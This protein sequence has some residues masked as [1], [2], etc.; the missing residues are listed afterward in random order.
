[1]K[2]FILITAL[3]LCSLS[4]I[5]VSG[6]E[7]QTVEVQPGEDVTL[8]CSNFTGTVA[9]TFWYRLTD[10]SNISCISS[11]T[12]ADSNAFFYDGFRNGKFNMTSNITTLF[13]TIQQVDLSDSGLY[14][15]GLYIDR[16]PVIDSATYL[17]VQENPHGNTS[18]SVILG[19]VTVFL[20]I[21]VSAVAVKISKCQTADNEQNPQQSENF[22][23]DDL[24]DAA[25]TSCPTAIRNRKPASEREVETRVVYTARR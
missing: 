23:S 5:S 10:R 22:C 14:I 6:S 24:K 17:K 11:M 16:K 8:M 7:S 2:K 12:T 19:A 21:V 20:I 15:C 13:L 18:L 1:M 3:L 4:W 9:Y 25:L